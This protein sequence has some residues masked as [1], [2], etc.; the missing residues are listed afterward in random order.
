MQPEI[1]GVRPF[2]MILLY[3]SKGT[4]MYWSFET[5]FKDKGLQCNLDKTYVIQIGGNFDIEDN[6]AIVDIIPTG[7]VSFPFLC[8]QASRGGG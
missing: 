8:R 5:F 7:C 3:S 6:E 2:R 1:Q 4:Q